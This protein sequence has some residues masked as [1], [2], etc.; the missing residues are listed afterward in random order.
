MR[1]IETLGCLALEHAHASIS[2]IEGDQV[3]INLNYRG[4]LRGRTSVKF[5]PFGRHT[6]PRFDILDLE[7]VDGD[8]IVEELGPFRVPGIHAPTL[9]DYNIDLEIVVAG[10]IVLQCDR[11]AADAPPEVTPP[12]EPEPPPPT[13]TIPPTFDPCA[14]PG[15]TWVLEGEAQLLHLGTYA[16]AIVRVSLTLAAGP[17]FGGELQIFWR[18]GS[19]TFV[20]ARA[21]VVRPCADVS[22]VWA[23]TWASERV[24]PSH[25]HVNDRVEYFA[26]LVARDG[27]I[28]QAIALP[29]RR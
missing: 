4:L 14:T 1:T 7:T 3:W 24:P 11:G 9:L 16:Q 19:S 28:L 5:Y 26:R 2:R 12:F 15:Y 22:S 21:L 25:P 27:T 13:T 29:V 23:V 17:D 18:N 20:K 6:L 10:E 8:R